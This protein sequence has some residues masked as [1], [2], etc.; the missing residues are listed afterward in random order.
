MQPLGTSRVIQAGVGQECVEN[1]TQT[2]RNATHKQRSA[3]VA[4]SLD[5]T[6]G[7]YHGLEV[8]RTHT[9]HGNSLI[10]RRGGDDHQIDQESKPN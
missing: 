3:E 4:V 7:T 5:L 6:V 2:N 10:Q 9:I 1:E 8:M